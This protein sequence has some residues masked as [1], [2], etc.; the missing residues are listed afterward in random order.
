M[1]RKG[2]TVV[3]GGKGRSDGR[4]GQTNSNPPELPF[5]GTRRNNASLEQMASSGPVEIFNIPNY[6]VTIEIMTSSFLPQAPATSAN[7]ASLQSTFPHLQNYS[8]IS[9]LWEGLNNF[10]SLDGSLGIRHE[11]GIR[12]TPAERAALYLGILFRKTNNGVLNVQYGDFPRY[13]SELVS[14]IFR[15]YRA[16]DRMAKNGPKRHPGDLMNALNH[17]SE[18]GFEQFQ[19]S[20]RAH[21][22]KPWRLDDSSKREPY[23]YFFVDPERV[24]PEEIHWLASDS[25]G[26]TLLDIR[27]MEDYSRSTADLI[28]KPSFVRGNRPLR[29]A[30]PQ[31]IENYIRMYV[32][33][34]ELICNRNTSQIDPSRSIR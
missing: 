16:I 28:L 3:G 18:A 6:G 1:N 9:K 22:R 11:V 20:L 4:S 25:N 5:D 33:A 21:W 17:V 23:G 10:E 24:R 32:A 14:Q 30:S 27:K 8:T 31:G 34:M 15:E 19:R 29:D 13:V 7:Q 12:M 2:F 26:S